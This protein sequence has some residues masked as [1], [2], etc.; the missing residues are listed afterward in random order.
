MTPHALVQMYRYRGDFVGKYFI[1]W[2]GKITAQHHWESMGHRVRLSG[3][4][5]AS[6]MFNLHKFGKVTQ[7]S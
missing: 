3:S 5:S 2:V 6:A 4:H 1:N 7:S